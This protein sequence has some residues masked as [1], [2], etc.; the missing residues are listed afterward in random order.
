M[1]SGLAASCARPAASARS[2]IW[3]SMPA[4]ASD[5]PSSLRRCRIACSCCAAPGCPCDAAQL[6]RAGRRAPARTGGARRRACSSMNVVRH[7][8]GDRRAAP[9]RVARRGGDEDQVRVRV[10]A[11]LERRLDASRGSRRASL[12]GGARRGRRT[13]SSSCSIVDSSRV[14]ASTLTVSYGPDGDLLDDARRRLVAIGRPATRRRRA[15]TVA[16]QRAGRS[17]SAARRSASR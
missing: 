7:R 13:V 15:T 16:G 2:A 11:G 3:R 6:L 12:L 1:R 14:S 10:D 17:A 4:A 8:V 5:T 9:L